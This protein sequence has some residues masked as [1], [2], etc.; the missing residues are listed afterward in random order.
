MKS[1]MKK[2]FYIVDNRVRFLCVMAIV[3]V[4][5]AGCRERAAVEAWPET[6]DMSAADARKIIEEKYAGLRSAFSELPDISAEE[7]IDVLSRDDVVVVD[8]RSEAERLVSMIPGALSME[9][10]EADRERYRSYTVVA[11]CTVGY[12]SGKYGKTL[13]QDGFE[14]RNLAGGILAWTCAGGPLVGPTGNPTVRVHVYG[15]SWNVLPPGYE[16]TW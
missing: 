12:R 15:S 14:V 13:A 8:V 6:V 7:L 1:V 16:A 10:F 4:V 3:S 5:A 9:K 11:Q 2:C